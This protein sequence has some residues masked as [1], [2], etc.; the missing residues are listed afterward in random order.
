LI[1][2]RVLSQSFHHHPRPNRRAFSLAE[3]LTVLVVIGVLATMAL[4]RFGSTMANHRADV[5]ATRVAAS[6]DLAR[7]HAR[8][9]GTARSV[10][11]DVN[12]NGY[13]LPSI[14]DLAHPALAYA[15]RLADPPYQSA[16][17]AA[18]FGGDTE[19]IFD[20]YGIPDSGGSVTIQSGKVQKTIS[21]DV[22]T[23]KTTITEVIV[24]EPIDL[25]GGPGD[26]KLPRPPVMEL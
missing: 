18:N 9:T 22:E 21:V 24:A 16:V 3:M 17:V 19:L 2:A 4:P 5:A 14:K 10:Q 7:R 23:G 13:I 6:L 8:N 26:P 25:G 11:F 15:V 1:S 12:A 20:A